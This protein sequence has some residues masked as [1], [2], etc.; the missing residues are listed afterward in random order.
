MQDLIYTICPIE[1]KNESSWEKGARDFILALAVAFWEDVFNG[2]MPREKFN[3][4]NLYRTISDYAKGECE[5]IRAYFD[6]RS[7]LSKTRGL[8]NTVLVAQ[9]R[10]LASFLTDVSQYF[11]WMSDTGIAALTSGNDIEF[12]DFDESPNV[13]F[14]KS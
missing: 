3:L 6:T 4:Y 5:D 1:N 12:G 9:D 14:F 7:P 2:F 11:N 8:S 10:T 13:L